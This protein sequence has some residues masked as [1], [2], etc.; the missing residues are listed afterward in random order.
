MNT[1]D[2]LNMLINRA[3]FE[4]EDVYRALMAHRDVLIQER[5]KDK[6]VTDFIRRAKGLPHFGDSN[7]LTRIP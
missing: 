6:K 3:Y 7:P 4:N 2:H 5:E 1:Q